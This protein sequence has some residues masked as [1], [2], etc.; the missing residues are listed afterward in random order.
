MTCSANIWLYSSVKLDMRINRDISE[1]QNSTTAFVSSITTEPSNSTE[2]LKDVVSPSLSVSSIATEPSY[3]TE[4]FTDL[5]STLQSESMM[6]YTDYESVNVSL[7][8]HE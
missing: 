2:S 7:L 3:S 8:I 1:Q 6:N 4:V 5:A